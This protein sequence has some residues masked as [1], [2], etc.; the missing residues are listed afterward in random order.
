MD[1]LRADAQAAGVRL[2]LVVS[3][4]DGRLSGERLRELV[5]EWKQASVWFC[6]PA[7]FGQ[8][9]RADLVANGL[10][11]EAFHQELFQMR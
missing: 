8:A 10:P 11:A 2:H 3:Q 4:R 5:P 9:L 1:E 7:A 6:G